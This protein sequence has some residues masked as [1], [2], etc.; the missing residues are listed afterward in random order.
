RHTLS[1]EA[2]SIEEATALVGDPNNP[3]ITPVDKTALALRITDI[4]P[5]HP[6]SDQLLGSAVIDRHKGA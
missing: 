1:I 3:R 5:L 2:A 4:R 6:D